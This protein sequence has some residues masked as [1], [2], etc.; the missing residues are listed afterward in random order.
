[1]AR[2]LSYFTPGSTNTGRPVM[3]VKIKR[4]QGT[5]ELCEDMELR[6]EWEEKNEALV[7]ARATGTGRLVDPDVSR[8]AAEVRE[9]EQAMESATLLFRLQAS[10]R[11][12]W[13][14]AVA[15]NPPREG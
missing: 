13:A 3:A 11:K 5:V 7:T 8:L 10:P 14:E 6:G 1:A 12:R 4:A 15:A 2:G 9:L